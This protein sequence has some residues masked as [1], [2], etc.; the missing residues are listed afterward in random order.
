MAKDK[1]QEQEEESKS[2]GAYVPPDTV[3]N[4]LKEPMPPPIT[5]YNKRQ[6]NFD[7]GAVKLLTKGKYGS[8]K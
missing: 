6:H 1:K 5:E 7:V 8:D 2:K 3:V 4:F